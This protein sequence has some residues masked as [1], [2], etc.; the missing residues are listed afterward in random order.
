MS[1]SFGDVWKYTHEGDRDRMFAVKNIRVFEVDPI[2]KINKV[3]SFFT[4][5]WIEG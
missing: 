4:Q 1:G 2:E 3:W 5:N